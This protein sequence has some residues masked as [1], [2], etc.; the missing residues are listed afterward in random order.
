M[1][2]ASIDALQTMLKEQVFWHTQD[3]KKAAG[4]ALGTLVELIAYYLLREWGL[5]DCISIER[6]LREYG[7]K[8]ITHNVEFLFHPVIRKQKAGCT[9]PLPLT[10]SKLC[11]TTN[12]DTYA[13]YTLKKGNSLLNKGKVL[14]NSCL[15]AEKEDAIIVANIEGEAGT[16]LCAE[17]SHLYKSPFAMVECKRVG[18]EDGCKK[19][20]QTIEKAKQGAYVAL[21]TSSLQKVCDEKGALNGLAY[22]HG[23]PVIKPYGELLEEIIESNDKLKGFT[24]S[25]GIVS[26]HGNWFTTE[27]K[28]KELEIL[29][30]AYDWLVFLT[31]EGLAQFVTDLLLSPAPRHEAARQAFAESYKQG[32]KANVFTK[33]RIDLAAH[34]AVCGYFSENIKHIEES[35]FNVIAPESKDIM[36]LKE[37]LLR[38]RNKDWRNFL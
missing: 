27:N 7:N 32:K 33:S 6:G 36:A 3:A 38:L 4:R 11:A 35:W 8:E 1:S 20:P 37:T 22:I 10:A 15:M 13:D 17:L 28:N 14:R 19:G 25:I 26:N 5:A 2:Y 23:K 16:R 12:G 29:G 24:M 34:E 9:R 31:D 21:K 30:Q 18:V